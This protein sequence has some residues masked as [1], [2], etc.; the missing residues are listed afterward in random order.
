MSDD[1]HERN[2]YRRHWTHSIMV[3]CLLP[4]LLLWSG[5]R[6]AKP[7]REREIVMRPIDQVDFFWLPA[8][9][10]IQAPGKA[11]WISDRNGCFLSASYM[12]NVLRMR[13]EGR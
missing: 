10:S 11:V 4:M 13:I 1:K 2:G 6:T 3:T 9:T 5:C 8:G 7:V 12:T